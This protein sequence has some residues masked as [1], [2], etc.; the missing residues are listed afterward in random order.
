MD[1]K[2]AYTVGEVSAMTG[3]SR[4]TITRLFER[5]R[6]VIVLHRPEAMHKRS[7]RTIRILRAAYERVM[8]RLTVR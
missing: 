6:G 2:E 3:L 7:Y 8:A 1:K 4:Q 5:E